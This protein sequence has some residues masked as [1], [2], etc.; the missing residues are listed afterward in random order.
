MRVC[1]NVNETR[2]E[3]SPRVTSA[4]REPG[5]REGEWT[6]AKI[7]RRSNG[8]R[9]G[10]HER[11]RVE[12]RHYHL[13]SAGPIA[14]RGNWTLA[15][16]GEAAIG[17]RAP[18]FGRRTRWGR[19]RES[20]MKRSRVARLVQ[21]EIEWKGRKEGR[22]DGRNGAGPRNARAT[23]LFLFARAVESGRGKTREREREREREVLLGGAPCPLLVRGHASSVRAY[24]VPRRPTRRD[25]HAVD[26][27]L[28]S[29]RETDGSAA[30]T[31]C[32]ISE[33]V[34]VVSPRRS[35]GASIPSLPSSLSAGTANAA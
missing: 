9:H 31:A 14:A 8:S 12:P 5:G 2:G 15:A 28:S 20:E 33:C 25:G 3:I 19:E 6:G 29:E 16:A 10:N 13:I 23:F 11:E 7:A 27:I 30:R 22:E 26:E 32:H 24:A 4:I 17:G 35:A 34:V 21:L 18:L 1:V